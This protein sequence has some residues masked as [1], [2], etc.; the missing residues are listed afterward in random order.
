MSKNPWMRI[1][2][3]AWQM[4]LEASQVIALRTLK[5]ASGT[6]GADAEASRMIHEKVE[7]AADLQVKAMSGLLG[8]SPQS[9]TTKILAHYRRKIRANRRRLLK[10]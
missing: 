6:E 4:G 10:G 5:I 3:S 7:T 9:A 1:G 2:L 8:L